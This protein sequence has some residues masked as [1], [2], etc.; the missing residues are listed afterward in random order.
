MQY[1]AL[2]AAA[3]LTLTSILG[4]VMAC[5]MSRRPLLVTL[6]LLTGIALPAAFLLL[7]R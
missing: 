5:R 7:A 4:I 6:L 3:G 2:G 1:F